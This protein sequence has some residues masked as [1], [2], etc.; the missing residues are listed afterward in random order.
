[1]PENHTTQRSPLDSDIM[2]QWR[3][4]LDLMDHSID[5]MLNYRQSG[6]PG[7]SRSKTPALIALTLSGAMRFDIRHPENPMGDRFVLAAGHCIP[8]VY[9]MLAVYN[10]ALRIRHE[11]TGQQRYANPLGEAGTLTWED[12]LGFRRNKGL[13]GHAEMEGKTL[14][15]KFNTG[16][17]GHGTAAV[18]GEAFALKR[19]G[20]R[21]V[22]VF[23]LEGEGGLTP[24]AAH[25]MKNAA[26]GYGLDN[27][28][29]IVDWN[30]YGIDAQRVSD[31]VPGTPRTWF[32]SYDWRV[33]GVQDGED[34]AALARGLLSLT[35]EVPTHKKPG[36]LWYRSRKG[37]GYG[38]YDNA[39]H[40]SPH[41]MNSEAF[42]STKQVLED[43]YN[44]RLAGFGQPAP[45]TA[46]GIQ[47]QARENYRRLFALL[48]DDDD[49][50]TYLA[51]RL[52]EVGESVP[53]KP[54]K[55]LVGKAGRNP[56][57]D[58]RFFDYKE[59]PGSLWAP[60]GSKQ[61]NRAALGRWGSYI[62]ALG[63][64]D[65]GRPLILA[66]SADLAESTSIAGLGKSFDDSLPGFGRYDR[67]HNTEG[68]LLPSVITEFVNSGLCTGAASVNFADDPF[69]EFDGFAAA[70]STYG[71]FAY[72]K[73]GLMRLYC[74]MSQDCEMK[75][76][77]VIWVAGHSGPETAEDS[78][79]HFGVFSPAVTQLFP[80]G[81]VVN[82]HPF[83]YNEV[84]VMLAEAF[85]HP[86]HI[87]ALHL[88][89]PAIE[90]PNRKELGIPHYF[91]AAR[92][93]YLLREYT[94]G[95]EQHGTVFVQGTI[96]TRNV[97]KILPEMNRIG[98]NIKL[99]AA[100]SPE[101]LRA[102]GPR[103][104][105]SLFSWED[106]LDS[107]FITNGSKASM[108]H[109]S[110]TPISQEYAMSADFDNRWRTGGSIEEV[111]EEAHLTSQ[112]ILEGLKRFSRDRDKR[113]SRLTFKTPPFNR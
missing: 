103:Y 59:Y 8:A 95:E 79:T 3:K 30:D 55:M 113:R 85:K 24:G 50:C 102:Q 53:R 41:P 88:T 77:K 91:E 10:E 99:I 14:F 5:L 18:L 57:K 29:Y 2:S 71:S 100:L 16:P 78:R 15:C 7:G 65:Y 20:A 87:I 112:H 61:P 22:N 43:R 28:F 82:L 90:I 48:R 38:K 68:V 42:W 45:E 75:M 51:D 104:R 13:A 17:S 80:K 23:A 35:G 96:T 26:W 58:P 105:E 108:D 81:Q 111:Y 9:S 11:R 37:R 69:A 97:L 93:A 31:V 36:A 64:R 94:P 49:L 62:N 67:E 106:F 12:L 25:E 6:H 101:L 27:L 86:A 110:A 72:L 33:K 32:E 63:R 44:I 1:M 56:W 109:W 76:G 70:C 84:P 73:Y 98:L 107:T 83:E 60:P 54:E 46:Q 4:I 66:A 40:G 47:E 39:S 34:L 74:Q 89:R 21:G 52:V 19:A 92:G